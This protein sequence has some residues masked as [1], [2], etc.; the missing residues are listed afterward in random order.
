[1]DKEKSRSPFN[2]TEQLQLRYREGRRPQHDCS[3]PLFSF[4]RQHT[5]ERTSMPID[6]QLRNK[7]IELS[8]E[9]RFPSK[10]EIL[11]RFKD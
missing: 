2:K 1:M 10:E 6:E 11:N 7:L 3:T 8:S 5:I 4:D 9:S